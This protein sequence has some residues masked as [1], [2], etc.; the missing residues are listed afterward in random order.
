MSGNSGD[1]T[2]H[3]W[4]GNYFLMGSALDGGRI[5]GEYP[6]GFSKNDPTVS[7]PSLCVLFSRDLFLF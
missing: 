7:F 2:D 3:A 1:G 6:K 5:L 4:G